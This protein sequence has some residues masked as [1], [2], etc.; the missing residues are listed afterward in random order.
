VIDRLL[1]WFPT[2]GPVFFTP[3]C[4][5]RQALCAKQESRAVAKKP[6]D[7]ACLCLCTIHPMN[8]RLLLF[9]FAA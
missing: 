1:V 4:L 5:C 2:G 8:L 9:T 6:R 7:A 3:L